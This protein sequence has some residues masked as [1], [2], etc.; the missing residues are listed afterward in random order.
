MSWYLYLHAERGNL[1]TLEH[2]PGIISI[3][4]SNPKVKGVYDLHSKYHT[5]TLLSSIQSLKYS[6]GVSQFF[7]VSFFHPL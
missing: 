7:V 2:A 6:R 4:A 5:T 1:I 3:F